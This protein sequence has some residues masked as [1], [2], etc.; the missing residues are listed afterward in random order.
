MTTT[1]QQP[2]VSVLGASKRFAGVVA[3]DDVSLDLLRPAEDCLCARPEITRE[4][5][6]LVEYAASPGEVLQDVQQALLG[7]G[8]QQLVERTFRTWSAAVEAPA[9]A[10]QHL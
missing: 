8:H 1:A 9:G 7:A 5:V 10:A 2:T 3:L 6:A 4:K